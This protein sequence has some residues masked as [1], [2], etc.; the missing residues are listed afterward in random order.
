MEAVR[1]ENVSFQYTGVN[2]KNG[3]KNVSMSVKEG[4]CVLLTGIS[5]CGKST[6]LRVI[7]GLVPYFYEGEITG[8][9]E[10]MGKQTD[11]IP[12]AEIS[13]I[14]GSVFQNPRSQFFYINTSSEIAFGCEN[15][16]I[17]TEEI[18]ARVADCVEQFQLEDLQNR[19]IMQLSGGEKQKIAFASI[20]AGRPDIYV[21]DEPSANLDF[22][23]IK[24]IERILKTLKK[25]GKTIIIAEH[26][27]YYLMELA[28]RVC[29]IKDGEIAQEYTI[30][31]FKKLSGQELR[32]KGLRSL[33]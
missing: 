1:L 13:K 25:Q 3:I 23:A 7:N 8:K 28:D 2:R 33:D 29:Y 10:L 30:E 22:D 32:E 31:E 11:E 5:G 24:D 6:I 20:Y 21:L 27:L 12:F 4:E 9:I 17:P 19:N 26:R 16:G 14:C 15:Q 18:E